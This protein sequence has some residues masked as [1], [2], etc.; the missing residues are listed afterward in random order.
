MN[1]PPELLAELPADFVHRLPAILKPAALEPL[2]NERL[3]TQQVAQWFQAPGWTAFRVNR[4]LTNPEQ[5]LWALRQSGLPCQ[6]VPWYADAFIT[7]AAH[8]DELTR[9]PLVAQGHLYLHNLSSMAAVLMLDPQ[10]EEKVLDLAA[11]PGGKT[12]QIAALMQGRGQLSAVEA[13]RGRFFK[14]KEQLNRGGARFV[15][16]FLMDGRRVAAKTGPRFDRVLLDAPCSGEARFRRDRPETFQRWSL[17]KVAQCQRKQRGLIVSAFQSLLPA[18]RLLYCTCSFAPEENEA[19]VQHLLQRFPDQVRLLD[20]ELPLEPWQAGLLNWQGRSFDSQMF[21]CRR[22]LP[23]DRQTALF[24]AL[25][26]K[27]EIG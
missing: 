15:R 9:H 12:L 25:I 2:D 17:R 27:L 7:P 14:L 13:V 23:S 10:P 5:A 21:R 8:R 24:L 3:T 18:G 4:L 16:T 1:W 11:A 19:V 22:I 6:A 26:E 20:I